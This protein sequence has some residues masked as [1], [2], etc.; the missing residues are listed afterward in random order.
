MEGRGDRTHADNQ[1]F[2]M[3]QVRFI[4]WLWKQA[5]QEVRKVERCGS[6]L[7][8]SNRKLNLEKTVD[9]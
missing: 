5:R 8:T 7:L 1:F 3:Q 4:M 9:F 2:L 6:S